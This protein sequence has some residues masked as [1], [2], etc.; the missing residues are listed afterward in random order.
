MN[1]NTKMVRALMGVMLD[2][3]KGVADASDRYIKAVC[4]EDDEEIVNESGAQLDE[5]RGRITGVV[6]TVCAVLDTCDEVCGK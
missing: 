6:E 4:E 1:M 5:A 2:A 3:V